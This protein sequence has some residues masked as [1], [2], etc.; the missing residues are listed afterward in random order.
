[1]YLHSSGSR[2]KGLA[3]KIRDLSRQMT[4]HK[5]H[6]NICLLMKEQK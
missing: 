6:C 2:R 1:M 5:K 3:Q 4:W